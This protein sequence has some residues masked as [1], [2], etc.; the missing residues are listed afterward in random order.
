[1]IYLPAVDEFDPVFPPTDQALKDPDGLLAIGGRLNTQTL[2]KAYRQGIF[3]WFEEGQSILW[4]CPS[5]RAVLTPGEEY[6]S[7]SMGKLLR[8]GKY[9]LT[10][11]LRFNEVIN[12]CAAPRASA[13]GTWIT[14]DMAQAYR[15]LHRQG[16]AHSVEC[17]YRDELVGGLYGVQVGSVFCGESMFSRI[18]NSSKLAFIALSRTLKQA[19]FTLIDCQLENPHLLSLGVRIISRRD[20]LQKL[21]FGVDQVINWPE[22]EQFQHFLA[23]V[24]D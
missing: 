10:S 3:P 8:Q 4:W 5:Q 20:F 12:Q 2:L 7:R 17:W 22:S 15:Q 13:H 24:N 11:N 9:R 19:G 23:E 18:S 14:P 21:A 16:Y 1:M 6:V